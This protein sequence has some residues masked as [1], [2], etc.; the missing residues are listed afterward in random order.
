MPLCR[1]ST[2]RLAEA[3][4]QILQPLLDAV[5]AASSF[6]D[7]LARIEQAF[8]QVPVD[9]LQGMLADA[10][11][12]ASI[13]G[14]VNGS[15]ADA[16]PGRCAGSSA[17]RGGGLLRG[18]G[19]GCHL[20]LA[21]LL[22]QQHGQVFTVAKATSLDVLRAIRDQV[23]KAVGDGQTFESFKR[24]LKPQLQA[25][26]WWGKQEVLDADTGELTAV[27]LGSDRRLR[28]I[29]RPMCRRP[30]WP[31]ASSVWWAMPATVRSGCTWRSWTVARGRRT[32]RSMARC[33]AG[34]IRSG[35]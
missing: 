35:G 4:Q 22:R 5:E 6:E 14:R 16:F 19:R 9:K 10:M 11:F 3:A 28:T 20:G 23:S 7:A 29:F 8:P 30:T 25:L 18:Q 27:Q 26:G 12:S 33:S 21:E 34:T 1:R 17:R 32:L 24:N 2:R 15:A 13:S 31:G